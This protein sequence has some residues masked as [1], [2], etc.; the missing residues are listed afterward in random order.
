[1]LNRVGDAQPEFFA[2]FDLTSGYY[3][4]PISKESQEFT[5]F[6]TPK[7][8]Y[9]WLR[10]PMGLTGGGSYFQHSLAT[11]VLAGLIHKSCELYLDD[12]MVNAKSAEEY[13]ERLRAVFARF[14]ASSITLNPSKCHLG[15]TQVEYV[16]HTINKNGLHFTRDK[17]DRVLNFPLPS[18]KKQVKSFLGLANYFRDHIR[19]HSTRVQPLQALVDKYDRKEAR[20]SVK[21]DPK[22]IAAFEDIR[23]A[24]DNCPALWFID[25]HSP[26]FLQTDASDYGIGA[27]LYQVVKQQDGT[28]SE[29][30]IGF[31]SK[32]IASSHSSWDTPMKEG[33]AIFYAL[34]KW[35]YLLRDR[36][37]T[38]LTDH[39]NL[40][41]LRAD[42]LESN[43]MVKR[44]FMAFQEY[45]IINWTY[46][47]G[48]DNEVPD[49][50]SRLC[51]NL[52]SKKTSNASNQQ[53]KTSKLLSLC[54]NKRRNQHTSQLLFQL[55]GID[56]PKDKWKLIAEVHN[57]S[58]G[59][60]G[61]ERTLTKLDD[62]EQKWPNRAKHVKRFIQLC[63]CCQKMNQMKAS[64][65]ASPFTT[66]AYGLWESVSVDYIESLV[67]DA[68]N[69]NMIIVIIDNFSRFVDLY[70]TQS[71]D[72]MGAADALLKFTG[73][74]ATPN[75]FRTDSGLN[76][77]SALVTGLIKTLGSD[78]ELTTAYSKEENA[79]V[80]RMNK[81]VLRHLRNIIFDKRVGN[82]W[83]RY[84][85]I[86]QRIINT[87]K[88]SSTGFTPAQI[89]FPNQ[90]TVGKELLPEAN[91]FSVAP[92]IREMQE[93][94]AKIIAL[95]EQ[96]LRKK[97]EKHIREYS[98]ERTEFEIGSYVL[99]EH[100]QNPL[101]RGPKS[102]LLPFLRGPLKIIGKAK[103]KPNIYVAISSNTKYH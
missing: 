68:F 49:Q 65:H 102:K 94:Q 62:K 54:C 38:I 78:H 35:E 53:V 44:W 50:F 15:L 85:P 98:K 89:V 99:A 29:H 74:Y 47:K 84:L 32:S 97:D 5:S 56:I 86:V 77:K 48:A 80:E 87:T 31:I 64:I 90:I 7:G 26:I 43:K 18:N 27:Y 8:I 76:F 51:Q 4:A 39:Q 28:E 13:L 93:A 100:R 10:L 82:Q 88:N 22:S 1:M 40:T 58:K 83:S 55:T 67:P 95:A 3:Q 6:M 14:R 42:H 61:V 17:L 36:Q 81:E 41:R 19:N 45:D 33:F 9:R 101:R 11:K 60:H 24:I 16:G 20:H 92:Y 21:W 69:N 70:P 103:S 73:R 63:P 96:H 37:F 59:H 66:S 91:K 71:T 46:V 30:P 75:S 72:A 79:L 12:C 2:V 52:D 57:S 25:N 23:A 34:K